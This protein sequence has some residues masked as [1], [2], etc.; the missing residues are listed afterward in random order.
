MSDYVLVLVSAALINHLVLQAEPV[1]HA[2]LHALGLCSALLIV[3]ALPVGMALYWQLLVPLQLQDLRLFIF[4]PLLAALAW[5]LPTLLQRL[6]PDWPAHGLQGLL[7]TNAVVLGLLL[8]LPHDGMDSWRLLAWPLVGA[9]GFWLAL[10][11]YADLG[12]RSRQ[13]EIPVALRGLPIQLIGAGVMAMAFSGF[14]G[15]FAP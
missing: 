1:E 2:R 13:A 14:N 10:I 11:L 6:R 8:Q 12:M 7:S 15:L 4:L 3:V 5:T 9:L